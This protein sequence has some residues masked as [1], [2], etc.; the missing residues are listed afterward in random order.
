VKGVVVALVTL[1]LAA[2]PA[3]AS[4]TFA[5]R[6]ELLK[7]Q[8]QLLLIGPDDEVMRRYDVALGGAPDGHKRREGD[9]RTPEGRYVIDWRNPES[10]YHLSLHISYPNADDR[11]RAADAGEDPGGMI[12]IHGLPDGMEWIGPLHRMWDWTNGCV[13]VTNS[14]IEEIWSLVRNGTPI[15]IMP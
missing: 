6:V 12:M 2:D 14:E 4:E 1:L 11:R 13:A 7:A 5:K 3:A 15:H 9:E 10:A 8:R